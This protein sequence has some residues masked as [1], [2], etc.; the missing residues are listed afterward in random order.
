MYAAQK[1]CRHDF[2]DYLEVK[3]LATQFVRDGKPFNASLP[4]WNNW[5][6]LLP[7][8]QL[9]GKYGFSPLRSM[10]ACYD[11]ILRGSV[12]STRI[13]VELQDPVDLQCV[14]LSKLTA[15]I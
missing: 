11:E 3:R 9:Q 10:F 1:E 13:P 4:V 6:G 12:T 15:R 7:Y 2:A 5:Y 14:L 8:F